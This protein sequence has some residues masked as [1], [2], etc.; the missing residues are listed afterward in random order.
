MQCGEAKSFP[1]KRVTVDFLR[2]IYYLL[3][4]PK[5]KRTIFVLCNEW[6]TS[7]FC[8]TCALQRG[9]NIQFS[10]DLCFATSGQHPVFV[11]LVLCNEWS[12]SS[13]VGLVLCNEWSISSFRRTCTLQ[14]VVNIQFSSSIRL[15]ISI[16]LRKLFIC[17]CHASDV[18]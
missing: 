4:V 12:T 13:F 5:D 15:V 2:K 1:S 8:R 14:R 9:V 11:G 16:F 3:I 7:S 10:S 6:S 18:W 17:C